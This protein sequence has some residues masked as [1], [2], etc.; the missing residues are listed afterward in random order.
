MFILL[1]L[2]VV[3]VVVV[4]V[5]VVGVLVVLVGWEKNEVVCTS[6]RMARHGWHAC[7]TYVSPISIPLSLYLLLFL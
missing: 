1:Y 2:H 5:V 6:R 7:G 3:T 4:A